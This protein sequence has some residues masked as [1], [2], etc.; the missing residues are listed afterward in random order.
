MSSLSSYVKLLLKEA[1]KIAK[2][3]GI[4]FGNAAVNGQITTPKA[5]DNMNI[6]TLLRQVLKLMTKIQKNLDMVPYSSGP[7]GSGLGNPLVGRTGPRT[8]APPVPI[9]LQL[10]EVLALMGPPLARKI[11]LAMHLIPQLRM[12]GR[13]FSMY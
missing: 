12:R 13:P 5:I 6:L 8:E 11:I 9:M 3:S 7:L 1:G 4:P 2:A 10:L